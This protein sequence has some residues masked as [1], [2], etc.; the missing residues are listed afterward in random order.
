MGKRSFIKLVL[1]AFVFSLCL[2]STTSFASEKVI[3]LRAA[4]YQ[5]PS[6]PQCALIKEWAKE[7]EEKTGGRVKVTVYPSSTLVGPFETY[8]GVTK[9]VTDIGNSNFSYSKGRF[10]MMEALEL[11]YGIK[12][13]DVGTYMLNEFYK[14][15]KPKELDD[16]KILWLE[17]MAP[18]RLHT[19]KPIKTVDD[20][21]GVRIRS[22]AFTAK[23]VTALGGTPVALPISEAYEAISK[24]VCDGIATAYDGLIQFK[25]DPL[26]KY[27]T[28]ATSIVYTSGFFW[29]MNKQKWESLPP[30]IQK[31]IDQM[32]EKYIEKAARVWANVDTESIAKL[33][34]DGHTFIELSPQEDA[35][36]AERMKPVFEDY[37]KAVKER[38]LPGDEA[39]RWVRDYLKNHDK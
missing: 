6:S 22:N 30:D 16:V 36:W 18:G 12:R 37:V 24:G 7:V 23:M 19:R 15:F 3:A 9:G 33:K 32:N 35:R 34:K 25:L 11:P 5:H 21:K 38:G 10:P 28:L 29:V 2:V 27:H 26:C 13:A 17:G 20:M 4:T 14:K 8:E 39:V 31:T 1:C